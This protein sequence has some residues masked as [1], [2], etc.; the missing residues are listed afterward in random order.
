MFGGRVVVDED[1]RHHPVSLRC[2]VDG[3]ELSCQL[4][5]DPTERRSLLGEDQEM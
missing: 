2:V 3:M 1:Y 5:K 4:A